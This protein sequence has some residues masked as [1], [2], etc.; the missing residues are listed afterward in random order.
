MPN[1][2][3][4][5]TGK[6]VELK[7]ISATP[8]TT[9][10]LNNTTTTVTLGTLTLDLQN[11]NNKVLLS[12]AIGFRFNA[13][14]GGV[15]LTLPG[16]LLLTIKSNGNDVYKAR[17][18]EVGLITGI[19]LGYIGYNTLGFEWMDDPITTSICNSTVVYD[20]ILTVENIGVTETVTLVSG[21]DY[22]SLT[23]SEIQQ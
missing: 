17:L 13:A 6:V 10:T 7:N 5:N 11:I 22:Y 3:I 20:F 23:A 14:V 21:Q 19:N 1:N 15:A 2:L 9:I 12:G 18:G 8:A 16:S 4:L